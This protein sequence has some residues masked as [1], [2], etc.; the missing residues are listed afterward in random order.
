MVFDRPKTVALE[1]NRRGE[2]TRWNAVFADVMLSLGGV[3]EV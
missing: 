2:V 1:W 3:A